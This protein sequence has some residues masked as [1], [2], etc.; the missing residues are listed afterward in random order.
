MPHQTRE[1]R[2]SGTDQS[3][4]R[5]PRDSERPP[6]VTIGLLGIAARNPPWFAAQPAV[7][8]RHLESLDDDGIADLAGLV[9]DGDAE[10]SPFPALR[11]WRREH[12]SMIPVLVFGSR[13]LETNS[14]LAV[15]VEAFFL[16]GE[17]RD[18][19]L[20]NFERHTR[21]DLRDVAQREARRARHRSW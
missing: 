13:A 6:S 1:R 19:D 21:D 17:P 15:S 5:D 8:V 20:A 2:G 18:E 4:R 16:V 11:R 10:P 14:K 12:L 9:V 7:S 3:A